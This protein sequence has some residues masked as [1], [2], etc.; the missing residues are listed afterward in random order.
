[1]NQAELLTTINRFYSRHGYVVGY[2]R[3]GTPQALLVDGHYASVKSDMADKLIHWHK[4]WQFWVKPAY[5]TE[6]RDCDDLA[7][8]CMY[9]TRQAFDGEAVLPFG[10]VCGTLHRGIAAHH[11]WNILVCADALV[12]Y[13]VQSDDI[14]LANPDQDQFYFAW[15]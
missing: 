9:E 3:F 2:N 13:D 4:P 15:L 10:V 1:M 14:W 6:T 11:A 5:K 12:M 8:R 7:I